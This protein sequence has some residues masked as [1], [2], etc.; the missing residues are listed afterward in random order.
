MKTLEMKINPFGGEKKSPDNIEKVELK[1]DNVIKKLYD[2][3]KE[4]LED[5]SN[6]MVKGKPDL[7]NIC[8]SVIIAR[9]C[10]FPYCIFEP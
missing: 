10:M 9:E 8:R 1:I 7:P 2:M 6:I 4:S 3:Y 5:E